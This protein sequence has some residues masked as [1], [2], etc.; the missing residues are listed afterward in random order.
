MLGLLDSI[1]HLLAFK[2]IRFPVSGA[3]EELLLLFRACVFVCACAISI[4]W[5]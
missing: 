2:G 1:M 5:A 4:A 3:E